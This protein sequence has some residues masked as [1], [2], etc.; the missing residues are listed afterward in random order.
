[1]RAGVFR[2]ADAH[3]TATFGH[4]HRPVWKKRDGPRLLQT[5]RDHNKPE[6][7]FFRIIEI[8]VAVR[9]GRCLPDDRRGRVTLLQFMWIKRLL[10]ELLSATGHDCGRG[11]NYGHSPP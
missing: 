4:E 1:V 6:I 7:P 2:C 3:T 5:F 10:P 11:S 8:D 9:Q